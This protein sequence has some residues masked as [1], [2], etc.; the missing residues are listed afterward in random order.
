MIWAEALQGIPGLRVPLP[1]ADLKH[2]FYK[3][4]FYVDAP[5]GEAGRLRSEIL[6]RAGDA[7]LRLFSG[8]CSEMYLEDAFSDLPRPDCPV[9]HEL[10]E[11]SLMVEVHP[12]LRPDLL[13][14]RAD[15]LAHIVREVLG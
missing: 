8:S 6:N 11:T 1:G 12:T 14:A 4:Y 2:A 3:F 15:L 13:K 9:A 7:G 10:T 5:L